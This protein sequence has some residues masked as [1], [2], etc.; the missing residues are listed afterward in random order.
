M[1]LALPPIGGIIVR[2][3]NSIAKIQKMGWDIFRKRPY[4]FE[5]EV[6]HTFKFMMYVYTIIVHSINKAEE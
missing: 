5:T 1:V 3:H 2:H 4:K 6:K